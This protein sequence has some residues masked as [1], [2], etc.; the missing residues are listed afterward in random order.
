MTAKPKIKRNKRTFQQ[1][2]EQLP[3]ITITELSQ[4]VDNQICLVRVPSYHGTMRI[5]N[6]KQ[7][8]N[9]C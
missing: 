1:V 3:T 7:N 9:N 5:T 8:Q 4:I 6:K 2:F